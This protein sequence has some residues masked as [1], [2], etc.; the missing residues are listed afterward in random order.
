MG[1]L[2]V[3]GVWV[4]V[5]R[6]ELCEKSL[7]VGGLVEDTLVKI[8]GERGKKHMARMV[9]DVFCLLAPVLALTS[10]APFGRACSGLGLRNLSA[11]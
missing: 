1:V 4:A 3:L 5:Q 9:G 2:W 7:K 11:F 8:L 10:E 6:S